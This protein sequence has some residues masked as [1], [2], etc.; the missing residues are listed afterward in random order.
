[1]NRKSEIGKEKLKKYVTTNI[2][3]TMIA[4]LAAF[5]E[6]YSELW[7]NGVDNLTE[8]QQREY[9]I[10]QETRSK[11]LDIGNNNI[12]HALNELDC[13]DVYFNGYNEYK[14]INRHKG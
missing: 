7:G 4:A 12:R 6:K 2:R 9:E 13:Y 8:E 3:T 1:M 10:W 5:E 11:I 14:V